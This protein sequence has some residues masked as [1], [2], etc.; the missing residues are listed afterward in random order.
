MPGLRQFSGV[1]VGVRGPW[2]E[3]RN[4]VKFLGSLNWEAFFLGVLV[5]RDARDLEKVEGAFRTDLICMGVP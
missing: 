2:L 3:I 4:S 1:S 5:L